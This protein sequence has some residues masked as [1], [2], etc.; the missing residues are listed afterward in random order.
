MLGSPLN[1]T[2]KRETAVPMAIMIMP[3]SM[4]PRL[5]LLKVLKNLGPAISPTAVTNMA[6]PRLDTRE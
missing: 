3:I 5:F 6:V 1:A 4:Y 2:T